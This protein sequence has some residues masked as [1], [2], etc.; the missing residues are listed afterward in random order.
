MIQRMHMGTSS[1]VRLS[2]IGTA[3]EGGP[4][5]GESDYLIVKDQRAFALRR[6]DAEMAAAN[7][8]AKRAISARSY[9]W[10]LQNPAPPWRVKARF[11]ADYS[12]A[13]RAFVNPGA[14]I[15]SV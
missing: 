6:F 8:C 7:G 15:D 12:D 4:R 10:L 5:A 3:R 14:C 11:M 9:F 2:L 1:H 13:T